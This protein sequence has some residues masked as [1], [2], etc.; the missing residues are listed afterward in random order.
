MGTVYRLTTPDGGREST[1]MLSA[2]NDPHRLDS[3]PPGVACATPLLRLPH[4][5]SGNERHSS[6]DGVESLD[7]SG[8]WPSREF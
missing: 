1:N 7:S 8:K 3:L 4:G 6:H 2:L 5:N